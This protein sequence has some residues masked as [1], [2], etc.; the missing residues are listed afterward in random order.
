MFFSSNWG[1]DSIRITDDITSLA[2]GATAAPRIVKGASTTINNPG[3]DSLVVDRIRRIIYLANYSDGN[4]LVFGDI[5]T[6]SGDVAPVRSFNVSGEY[7]KE[8]IAVDAARNRLYVAGAL[9]HI[10]IF[11]S[12]STLNGVVTPD[13]TLTNSVIALFLDEA[14]DRLYTAGSYTIDVYNSAGTLAS[15]AVPDRTITLP[16]GYYPLAIWVDDLHNRL[17]VGSNSHTAGGHRLVILPNADSLSGA[18]DPDT[19]STAYIDSLEVL[20]CM[21]DQNDTLYTFADS[22]NWVRLYDHASTLSGLIGTP[23][24]SILGVVY[25]GYGMDYLAY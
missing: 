20:G 21:I 5:T 16:S 18:C 17:Y 1:E 2:D 4:V 8:G 14:N 25:Y 11:N 7:V 3:L 10:W 15:G 9:G 23:D 19:Q 12:A 22:A 13:A 6:I 24:K